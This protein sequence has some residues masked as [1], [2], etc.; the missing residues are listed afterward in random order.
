M[1]AQYRL[2][3]D[4]SNSGRAIAQSARI[5]IASVG[6]R[7]TETGLTNPG[8]RDRI[9]RHRAGTPDRPAEICFCWRKKDSLQPV[10]FILDYS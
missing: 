10:A 1:R 4:L 2:E 5:L 8:P 6:T 9:K 3:E 7:R